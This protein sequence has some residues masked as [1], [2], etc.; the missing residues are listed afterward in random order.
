MYILFGIRAI[1]LIDVKSIESISS[2]LIAVSCNWEHPTG[3]EFD[4]SCRLSSRYQITRTLFQIL[5]C[6]KWYKTF[7]S[8][9][10]DFF[11][12]QKYTA[13]FLKLGEPF[14]DALVH[15][16]GYRLT[17]TK[18]VHSFRYFLPE[19]V[20]QNPVVVPSCI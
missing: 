20:H 12:S 3:D 11:P 18:D 16:N 17:Y 15:C 9:L 2:S 5:I 19:C 10:V 14:K 8:D 1:R 13:S 6:L 7:H 4:F